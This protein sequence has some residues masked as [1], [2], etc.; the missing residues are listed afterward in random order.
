MPYVSNRGVRIHYELEGQGAPLVL[1]HGFSRSI[2][3]W[4]ESGYV[5]ELR[6]DYRLI[7]VDA[8]GHGDS[9]KPHD[10]RAYSPELM[11]GD[12]VAVLDDLGIEKANYWGYSMG[13]MIGF[14]LARL[15]PSRFS[16]YII[17]GMS[18]YPHV[19]EA[20]KRFKAMIDTIAR[21]GALA[22]ALGLFDNDFKAL[23]AFSLARAGWPATADMLSSVTVPCLLYAGDRDPFHDGA[24]EA[25][26]HIQHASFVSIPGLAHM[27]VFPHSELI[28]PHAKS[29]LLTATRRQR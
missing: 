17:G 2:K 15:Y 8:R 18:P 4:I 25:A 10:P 14:Q 9:E 21:L 26:K 24:K 12:T 6:G 29:F 19:S 5:K 7:L 16:S 1:Q 27:E 3:S 13:G 11:T 22:S 20:E 23:R 28:L